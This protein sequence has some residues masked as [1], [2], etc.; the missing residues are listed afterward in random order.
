[1]NKIIIK[2]TCF[3]RYAAIAVKCVLICLS[4]CGSAVSKTIAYIGPS[5][6]LVAFVFLSVFAPVFSPNKQVE[7]YKNPNNKKFEK[8]RLFFYSSFFRIM[9][10]FT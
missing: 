10:S 3:S 6:G 5:V 7:S 9:M 1:M 2:L 4:K 8:K